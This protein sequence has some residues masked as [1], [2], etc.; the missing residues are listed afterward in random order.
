MTSDYFTYQKSKVIQAL[1]YH[2]ITRK[3]IKIMIVAVNVFA[4]GSA[5]LFFFKKLSPFGFMVGSITWFVLMVIFWFA[6]PY[7]VYKRSKTFLDR[8]KVTLSDQFTLETERGSRS[9]QWSDFSELRESPH[10]FHL[11]FNPK[12]FFLIPKAAFEDDEVAEARSIL[13]RA[14]NKNG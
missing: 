4:I 13:N 5:L 3:E 9:W 8:F 1:R 14:I 6:L 2:F 11:Y 7:S 10:F 12:S